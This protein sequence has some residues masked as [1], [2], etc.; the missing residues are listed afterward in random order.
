MLTFYARFLNAKIIITVAMAMAIIM[1]AADKP[2]YI[3]VFGWLSTGAGDAVVTAGAVTV[4]CD[5]AEDG[6]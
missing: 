1:A 3:S 5:S 2:M 6:Q 4:K